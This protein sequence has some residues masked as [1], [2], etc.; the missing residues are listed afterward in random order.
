MGPGHQKNQA[1]IRSLESR[2]LEEISTTSDMQMRWLDG[3]IVNSKDLS[4]NKLW[5]IV[6]DREAWRAAVHGV[7][8]SRIRLSD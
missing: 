1:M 7:T 2:L 4:L 3:I 6:M 5:E 8:R